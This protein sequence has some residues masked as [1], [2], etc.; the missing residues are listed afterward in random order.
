M[1][2]S[3]TGR[4]LELTP[5]LKKYVTKKLGKIERFYS[6]IDKCDVVL[7]V[8]KIR[9]IAEVV[10]YLR[11]T[12]IVAKE[13]SRDIHS[14]IDSASDIIMKQLRRLR[15]KVFSKRRKAVMDRFMGRGE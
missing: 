6:R 3:I 14:S 13:S 5:E 10:V 2:I 15:G 9:H 8:E 11:R 12:R 4:N 7:E 1:E